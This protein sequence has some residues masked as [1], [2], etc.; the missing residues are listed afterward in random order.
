M[1][2]KDEDP[3]LTAYI[4]DELS[5]EDAAE[6][7][8]LLAADADA[9]EFVD[10]MK[11]TT[12]ALAASLQN[13]DFDSD[14]GEMRRMRIAKAA[15]SASKQSAKRLALYAIPF[16]AAAAVLA[17][18]VL[19]KDGS[20][21]EH[22][23]TQ[24]SSNSSAEA[25]RETFGRRG[26]RAPAGEM[27]SSTGLDSSKVKS[28]LLGV[29]ALHGRR[30]T[31]TAAASVDNEVNGDTGNRADAYRPSVPAAEPTNGLDAQT[32]RQMESLGY[33]GGEDLPIQQIQPPPE[34]VAE[35]SF[36]HV[37]KDPLSTF[38][39]DV[40]TA[41]YSQMRRSVMGGWL[42][43]PGQVRIE[44][45][46]NYFSYDYASANTSAPFGVIG[47]VAQAPWN[48]KHKLV[49]IGIK[50]KDIEDGR[51][52]RANLVF[53]L[54]VSGSMNNADKLPLIKKSFGM[55]L[56]ALEPEDRIAIV[57]YAG[58]SG[59]ALP[60]TAVA[61]RGR[62]LNALRRLQSGGSTNGGAGIELAYKIAQDN[63]I[64][65]GVNRV[66]LAT[67]GDFNVG[68]V[69]R[70]DLVQLIE[71][72][73]K[74]DVFLT[75]L[76]VG[77]SSHGDTTMETLADKGNGNYAYIDT[78]NEAKKVLVDQLQG[79]LVT[80]AKDVKLQVE[81]N[82]KRVAEYRLIGYE[83]RR[84]ANKDFRDDTK[85]AGE[86]GAG[87]RV[88]ALYEIVPVSEESGP[89]L[90]Y[91]KTNRQSTAA[92]DSDELLTI[93]IRYKEPTGTKSKLFS[94]AVADANTSFSS[95]SV[96]FR[97]ASAVAAFGMV[98]R[99]SRYKGDSSFAQ[100]ES[101]ADKARGSDLFGYRAEF[102]R[103]V[104]RAKGLQR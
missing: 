51:R 38:S 10:S 80:V 25:N 19:S 63:F 21:A 41:S 28:G 13:T 79:T 27:E 58:A 95:A 26:N 29:F 70:E 3:R 50:A 104:R 83:N 72:K 64:E 47:E 5:P 12:Q 96:D 8:A 30:G 91:Q 69:A 101:W 2:F 7:A 103:I 102:V 55:L 6:V 32:R 36:V 23:V 15:E 53:L 71:N 62:I 78:L 9:L 37:V 54:D 31:G 18:V 89:E 66:I 90:R 87:H 67:D 1:M 76:G 60:S 24:A 65:G 48:S 74:Q 61:K 33:Y 100:I 4:L 88:T 52:R 85:D 16:V 93:K 94:V 92:A 22:V 34:P 75:V 14:I 17:L 97:F 99:H 86:I 45:M 98:L 84:L 82:P 39:I 49:R 40:D 56:D 35:S 44:E 43:N 11:E 42:P 20:Q 46:L 73:A 57:V 59:L 77:M 68:T 81:F